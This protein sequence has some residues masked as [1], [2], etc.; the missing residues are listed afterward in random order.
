MGSD[1]KPAPKVAPFSQSV[2]QDPQDPMRWNWSVHRGTNT[3][4]SG[5]AID[6]QQANIK[7]GEAMSG[8][9]NQFDR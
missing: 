4:K 1:K 8:M 5:H 7:A 3:H 6:Y 9:L 2:W